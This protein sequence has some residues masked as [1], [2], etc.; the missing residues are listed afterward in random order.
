MPHAVQQ[1]F[2][3]E[4]ARSA[5]HTRTAGIIIGA[6]ALLER[7]P[8]PTDE[9]TARRLTRTFCRAGRTGA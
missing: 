8:D 3:D 6:V 9:E 2:L 7:T 1:A 4:E 5:G